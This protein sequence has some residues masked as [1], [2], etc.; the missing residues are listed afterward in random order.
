[1]NFHS[2]Y[3]LSITILAEPIVVQPTIKD[4]LELQTWHYTRGALKLTTLMAFCCGTRAIHSPDIIIFTRN[5]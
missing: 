1:M 4:I 3:D 2:E 5:G